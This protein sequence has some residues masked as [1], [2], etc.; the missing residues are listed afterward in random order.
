MLFENANSDGLI[1]MWPMIRDKGIK[2]FNIR[3]NKNEQPVAKKDV[4]IL[5]FITFL[6]LIP[7]PRYSLNKAV[8]A[9]LV[10]DEVILISFVTYLNY[11]IYRLEN[12]IYLIL[13]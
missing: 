2:T 13:F 3:I 11:F 1:D 8:N 5:N 7:S 12:T 6:K 4:D 10:Y 9:L